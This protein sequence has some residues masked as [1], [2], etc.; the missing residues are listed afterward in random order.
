MVLPWGSKTDFFSVTYTLDFAIALF[1]LDRGFSH[2]LFFR[3]GKDPSED[4][5]HVAEI[6]LEAEDLGQL[7]RGKDLLH[8][9]VFGDAAAEIAVGAP[10]LHGV[11]LHYPV[12]VFPPH[13]A[14]GQLE[15]KL[16]R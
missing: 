4:G 13:A 3:V 5:V 10:R 15:K 6:P 11:R 9:G 2:R 12:G 8:L 1:S 7:G 16:P 14:R